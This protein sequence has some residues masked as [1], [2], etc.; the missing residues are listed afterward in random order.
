ML[1][2][3]IQQHIRQYG[4]MSVANYMAFCLQ[5]PEYGYYRK[6]QAVGAEGDFITA[7]EISQIF[8]DMIGLW[9]IDCWQ[10]MGAPMNI[11]LVELGPGRGTLSADVLRRWSKVQKQCPA[12]Q[13]DLHLVE[14]NET[15]REQQKERLWQHE[16]RWHSDMST[17]PADKPLFVLANEF[18]D[19]LPIQQWV[20]E[21]E[22]QVSLTE[23]G[24]LCFVP[25]G[26]VTN[27]TCPA[28]LEIL[29]TLCGRIQ[30]QSGLALIIDYG[31]DTLSAQNG[32]TRDTLQALKQHRFHDPLD[33]CGEVDLTAHVDF[34]A[35]KAAAQGHGLRASDIETQGMFLQRLGG[36]LWLHKLLKAT[37]DVVQR[38]ALGQG[39][40]RLVSSSQMGE[41]F[42]VLAITPHTI[43]PGG[44]A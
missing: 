44:F 31:Y 11:A 43:T 13:L 2:Q 15:L 17:L 42:K 21:E 25:Q 41:L 18:F 7:P 30:R 19:A 27:E 39:W 5:H 28:A 35:L 6:A 22:R 26:D 33:D 23:E 16:P 29:D 38:E 3:I 20:G 32:R 4:P 14:S 8:G 12:L 36:E 37:D 1:K 34:A 9:L 40:Q 24:A 10:Q